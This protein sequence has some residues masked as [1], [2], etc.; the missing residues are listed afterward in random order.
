MKSDSKCFHFLKG[1]GKFCQ[2]FSAILI[3][4][5]CVMNW[6]YNRWG[7][8]LA[9]CTMRFVF[10]LHVYTQSVCLWSLIPFITHQWL[11]QLVDS[12]SI[13]YSMEYIVMT[14]IGTQ[15]VDSYF[16]STSHIINHLLY[17]NG[18]NWIVVI[19][20]WLSKNNSA[21]YGFFT[22][23]DGILPK[24]PYPP[25]LRMADR[26]LLAGY[27]RIMVYQSHIFCKLVMDSA[28]VYMCQLSCKSYSFHCTL[29]VKNIMSVI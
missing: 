19:L 18:I 15:L 14:V 17:L 13:N 4:L 27:P 12:C 28:M 16:Y 6:C 26:T 3:R 20:S 7:T 9:I 1:F 21:F 8:P 10:N 29:H 25:C 24:G 5:Q 22:Q 11:Q 2:Q 23:F